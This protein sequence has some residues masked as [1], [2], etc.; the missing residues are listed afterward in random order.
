MPHS[1]DIGQPSDG[2]IADFQISGLSLIKENCHNFRTSDDIDMKLGPVTKL[3]KG[4]KTISKKKKK[5]SENCDVI[6]N[7][8]I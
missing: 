2:G 4:N 7:F 5:N 8:L 6:F 3:D 1:P